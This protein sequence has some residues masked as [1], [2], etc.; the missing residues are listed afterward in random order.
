MSS[1]ECIDDILSI[2]ASC[3][4]KHLRESFDRTK[5]SLVRARSYCWPQRQVCLFTSP[6]PRCSIVVSRS[7]YQR[8]A[9]KTAIHTCREDFCPMRQ[10]Q[11]DSKKPSSR[12]TL[13]IAATPDS[14]SHS[15]PAARNSRRS[16]DASSS[17]FLRAW[18][19]WPCAAAIRIR[20]D[21]Q[22]LRKRA[23]FLKLTRTVWA[24]RVMVKRH[25]VFLRLGR[26]AASLWPLQRRVSYHLLLVGLSHNSCKCPLSDITSRSTE[27][28]FDSDAMQL[29]YCS[30]A[31]LL[32]QAVT[33][34]TSCFMQ[35]KIAKP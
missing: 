31:A 30:A 24:V 13:K 25:D 28:G 34:S 11:L 19:G 17:V 10:S 35:E 29:L 1:A 18:G 2:C 20:A 15:G 8:L 26:A 12:V 16:N 22:Q 14:R 3:Q 27:I 6:A 7:L 4:S 9:H 32:L 5:F 23:E 33:A 21:L